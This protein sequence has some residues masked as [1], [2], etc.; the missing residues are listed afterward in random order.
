MSNKNLVLRLLITAK[1][2]ASGALSSLQAK[3]AAVAAAIGAYFTADFFGG[4]IKG[5]ADFEAAMSR[6]AAATGATGVTFRMRPRNGGALVFTAPGTVTPPTQ[7]SYQFTGTQLDT[8]GE[9]LLEATLTFPDGEET[10][11]TS[12]YVVVSIEP[13]LS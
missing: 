3:A 4:A 13:R 8:P 2:E 9:Y 5:A 10:A 7:V 11:P 1:D 6:V 12:G